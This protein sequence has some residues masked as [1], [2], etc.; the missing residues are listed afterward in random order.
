MN[1]MHLTSSRFYG[2]PERQMLGLAEALMPDV[3]TFFASFS[4]GGL[5][6]AFLEKVHQNGFVPCSL[7]N[8]TPRMWAAKNE[9]VSLIERHKIDLLLCHGYKATTIGWFAAR[10]AGLPTIAVS[11]GWTKEDWKIRI[12]EHLDRFM[13]R[14]MDRVVCVSHGQADKAR[15][16]GVRPEHLVVIHNAINTRRFSKPDPTYREKLLEFFPKTIRPN[17][18]FII[19]AAG[20]LS[21][22][23][24]FEVLVEAAQTIAQKHSEIGF[25][26]F[27][28]GA[29]REPLQSQIDQSS[30]TD[31]FQ[32]AGYTDELDQFMPFLDMFVQSSYTEG[33]PNVL[34]EAMA[35]G[36]PI[37]ATDVG[38]TTELVEPGNSC[39]LL[40]P[41][42][43]KQLAQCIMTIKN[44]PRSPTVSSH[45][46]E[47]IS[48]KFSFATQRDR[49]MAMFQSVLSAKSNT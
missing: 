38:G 45:T 42:S 35:T 13:L 3:R 20:R 48:T 11:R 18:E 25:V 33:L 39:G 1:V 23:K 10:K 32:L 26:L 4:E 41:G 17:I 7:K 22:E 15:Q 19:G 36:V 47:K 8:D 24:G 49:Y 21:P 2:G 44:N 30:L 46:A 40:E 9:I 16:A 43:S 31:R 27:G 28:E 12:Y 5:N 34:L 37:V 29:L 6:A 14:R